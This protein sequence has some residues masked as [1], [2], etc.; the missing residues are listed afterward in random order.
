[1]GLLQTA[2]ANAQD[3]DTITGLQS[4]A[5]GWYAY[6]GQV[7]TLQSQVNAKQATPWVDPATGTP[8]PTPTPT[9]TSA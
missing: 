7:E 3:P 2:V 5:A 4:L 1:M 9:P 8:T 6:I